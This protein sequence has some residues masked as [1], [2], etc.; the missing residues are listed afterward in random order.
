MPYGVDKQ[1][2]GDNKD[3]ESWMER[4]VKGVMEKNNKMK[5]GN[6]IAI[7]K[8]QMKKSKEKKS[9]FIYDENIVREFN[10][11]REQWIRK[12]MNTGKTFNESSNLFD[13][14]ISLNNYNY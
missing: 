4:C 9:E 8:S 6:A 1:L 7:C 12:S 14:Y 10:S 11:Y 2:G 3:N 13:A 5:E